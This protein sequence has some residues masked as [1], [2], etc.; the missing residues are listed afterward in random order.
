[1][2]RFGDPNDEWILR[3]MAE[4]HGLEYID[5]SEVSLSPS[6][7]NLLPEA[8]AR[9]YAVIPLAE[10]GGK[11]TIVVSDPNDYDTFDALRFIA[12]IAFPNAH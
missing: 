11:L 1:M 2:T 8:A 7:V 9:K 12:P 4:Q 6:V 10:A 5:L 3:K